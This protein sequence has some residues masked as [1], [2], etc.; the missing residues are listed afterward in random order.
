VSVSIG[1]VKVP[2]ANLAFK[3]LVYTG[4]IQLNVLIP[5]TAPTGDAVPLVVTIGGASSRSG[6]T[7]AIK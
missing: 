2:D 3:G 5:A 4:E 7:V 6:V 1:G